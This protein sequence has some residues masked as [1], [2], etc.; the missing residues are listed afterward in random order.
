MKI[1]LSRGQKP[2]YEEVITQAKEIYPIKEKGARRC[3]NPAS[4][5]CVLS[6]LIPWRATFR[7]L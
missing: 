3:G 4:V 6:M 5:S 7:N 2:G 1:I